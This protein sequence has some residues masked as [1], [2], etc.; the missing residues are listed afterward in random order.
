M[1]EPLTPQPL[2]PIAVEMLFANDTIRVPRLPPLDR[3]EAPL[4]CFDTPE[5]VDGYS[6]QGALTGL[7]WS[8]H[9]LIDA[10]CEE[11]IGE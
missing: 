4:Y 7:G 1:S 5:L 10:V 11:V 9:T 6:V 2:G 3:R 8:E